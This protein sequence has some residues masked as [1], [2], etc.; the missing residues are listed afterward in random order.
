MLILE[1]QCMVWFQKNWIQPEFSKKITSYELF[2]ELQQELKRIIRNIPL[3]IN[4]LDLSNKNWLLGALIIGN[5]VLFEINSSILTSCQSY[6]QSFSESLLTFL[7][8][9]YMNVA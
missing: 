2:L 3:R 5:K 4:E 6:F 7:S 9:E 1:T 8:F